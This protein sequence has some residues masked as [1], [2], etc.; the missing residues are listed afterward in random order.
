MGSKFYTA[1]PEN[2]GC[3]GSIIGVGQ[4]IYISS[5]QI[6]RIEYTQENIGLE[7]ICRHRPI[8]ALYYLSSHSLDFYSFFSR[9]YVNKN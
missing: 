9:S 2:S 8:L 6:P 1:E 4:H 5:L 7:S 3:P